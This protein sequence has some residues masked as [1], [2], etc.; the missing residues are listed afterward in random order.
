[1]RRPL[2]LSVTSLG[3]TLA[4]VGLAGVFAIG[5]DRAT[6]G[7]NSAETG[8][9]GGE[10]EVEVDL[11]LATAAMPDVDDSWGFAVECGE[12][13]DDLTTGL[14][15]TTPEELLDSPAATAFC[16]RNV[17]SQAAL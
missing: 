6:T 16:L 5:S 2:L 4:L 8:V 9:L 1:R 10:H 12:F 13:A 3:V 15:Q 17:G 7:E 14:L 11:E